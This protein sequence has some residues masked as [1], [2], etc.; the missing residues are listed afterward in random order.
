VLGSLG[1]GLGGIDLPQL[2][3]SATLGLPPGSAAI[4]IMAEAAERA[5]G[6]TI[7]LGHL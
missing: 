4:Q 6:T 2:D 1:S 3:V 5:P 7:V